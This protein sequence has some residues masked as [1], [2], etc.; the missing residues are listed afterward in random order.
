ME[1]EQGS[2]VDS[3][4]VAERMQQEFFRLMDGGGGED[5]KEP[6]GAEEDSLGRRRLVGRHG[7]TAS[8]RAASAE[9]VEWSNR[10]PGRP[11]G[12]GPQGQRGPLERNEGRLVKR[13]FG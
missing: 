11:A 4:A 2:S 8:R 9:N 10:P 13:D 12:G 5:L 1:G 6:E 7:R 3:E